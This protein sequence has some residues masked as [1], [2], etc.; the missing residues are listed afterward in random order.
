L[1]LA[2][3]TWWILV[4]LEIR[5]SQRLNARGQ[6]FGK[7]SDGATVVLLAVER[8]PDSFRVARRQIQVIHINIHLADVRNLRPDLNPVAEILPREVSGHVTNLN[9]IVAGLPQRQNRLGLERLVQ[10]AGT[11]AAPGEEVGSNFLAGGV[12]QPHNRIEKRRRQGSGFDL[13][14]DVLRSVEMEARAIGFTGLGQPALDRARYLEERRVARTCGRRSISLN[15]F[16]VLRLAATL[17]EFTQAVW[18][19]ASS[20]GALS[21]PRGTRRCFLGHVPREN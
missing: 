11:R 2:N 6:R 8:H 14:G 21:R 12:E 16:R 13:D 3:R 1:P 5:R 18:R 19:K 7:H 10:S 17:G 4:R 9:R 20:K 15:R